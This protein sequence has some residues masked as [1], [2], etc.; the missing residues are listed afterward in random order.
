MSSTQRNLSPGQLL[1]ALERAGQNADPALIRACLDRREEVKPGLLDMFSKG[2]FDA[3]EDQD[4]PRWY[5]VV[6]AGRLLIAMREPAA[7][8]VFAD[9]Y[10]NHDENLVEPFETDPYYFGAAAIPVFAELL[11]QY[12]GGKYHYGR[13]M[14]STVLAQVGLHYPELRDEVLQALRATLPPLKEDGTPDWPPDLPPDSYVWASVAADLSDL[15]DHDSRPQILALFDQDWMDEGL[16]DK[17][18]YLI[19]LYRGEQAWKLRTFD[20]VAFY[21]RPATRIEA[22]VEKRKVGRNDPCP[23]GSGKKYKKCHGQPALS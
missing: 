7:L 4:D 10:A 8:P 21:T 20:I 9:I 12:D 6:H 23:C 5:R 13:S 1:H 17:K 22:P 14:C 2:I 15:G 11:H 3:W 19:G 16:I 18:G